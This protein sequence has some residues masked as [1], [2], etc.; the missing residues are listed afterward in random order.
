M[1]G[2]GDMDQTMEMGQ[3]ITFTSVHSIGLREAI[4]NKYYILDY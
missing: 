2:N 4:L 3:A 1:A